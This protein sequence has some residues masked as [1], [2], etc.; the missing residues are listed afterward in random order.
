MEASARALGVAALFDDGGEAFAY[1]PGCGVWRKLRPGRLSLKD[2]TL[3]WGAIGRR[4][5]CDVPGCRKR[6]LWLRIK[7]RHYHD[8]TWRVS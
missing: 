5:R 7:D 1:C 2:R 6:P 3:T 4:L 8:A